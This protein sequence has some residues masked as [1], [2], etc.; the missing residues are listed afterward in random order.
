MKPGG[1]CR[2]FSEDGLL[3]K[4]QKGQDVS[5]PFWGFPLPLF[6]CSGQLFFGRLIFGHPFKDHFQRHGWCTTS[7]SEKV[8]VASPGSRFKAH[9]VRMLPLHGDVEGGKWKRLVPV[10]TVWLF[11]SFQSCRVLICYSFFGGGCKQ[12]RN[13]G[14]PVTFFPSSIVRQIF[15]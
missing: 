14:V 8:T 1:C 2:A 3:I 13:K 6:S 11:R 10:R 7:G 12:A 9:R 5:W 15:A 4:N